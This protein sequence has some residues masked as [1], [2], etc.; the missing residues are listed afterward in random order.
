M[1]VFI[2][3]DTHFG[4]SNLINSMRGQFWTVAEMDATLIKNWNAMV[5]PRDTIYHLGDFSFASTARTIEILKKLNGKKHL[6]YGNHDKN[7]R[8]DILKEFFVWR[9]DY[10]EL[11]YEGHKIPLSHYPMLEW[12]RS[13]HGAVMF[14]GHMHGKSLSVSGLR[15]ADAGTDT[16]NFKPY[17]VLQLIAKAQKGS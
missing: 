8:K 11:N 16:N 3:S 9:K 4:H 6:V 5:S 2:T 10:Y 1:T 14:H 17:T 15:C 12:N 7:M 13:R